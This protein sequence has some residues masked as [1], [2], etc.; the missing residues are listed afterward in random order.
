MPITSGS[1]SVSSSSSLLASARRDPLAALSH[2]TDR[3]RRILDLLDEHKVATTDQLERVF[4]TS[5]R[6]CQNRLRLLHQLGMLDRFRYAHSRYRLGQQPWKWTL[7][8]AGARFQAAA[9]GR[10]TSTDRA[11]RDQVLRLSANPALGHLLATNEFFVRL[12]HATRTQPGARVAR[13]WSEKTATAAFLGIQPDGHLLWAAGGATVGA[14]VEVDLATED[15]ARVGQ[16]LVGYA[17]LMASGG[18]RYPVLFWLPSRQREINLRRHLT[19]ISAT[20]GRGGGTAGAVTVP[21]ATATHDSDPAG[22]VWLPVTSWRRVRL[23][24]LP[25][26]QD[27][28][29]DS[30]YNPNWTGGHLDL[31]AYRL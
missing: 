23:V 1:S 18:P 6:R 9:H 11:H 21:V 29:P 13:W 31:P 15:L 20:S 14:F 16:K 2:L 17:R 3:D 5:T 10:P 27:H 24:D 7:G 8:L 26:G 28:G 4:F 30:A 19:A 25:G 22:E 12:L